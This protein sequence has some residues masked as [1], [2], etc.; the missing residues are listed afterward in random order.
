[1]GKRS[2]RRERQHQAVVGALRASADAVLARRSRSDSVDELR[3]LADGRRL[4]DRRI[5]DV[6]DQLVAKGISWVL[7]AGALGVSRQ[8]A[9]QA[10]LRR[11]SSALTTAVVGVSD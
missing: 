10:F 6:V 11:S 1:M 7:I 9:R 8:A 3:R 4:I 5:E 2:R